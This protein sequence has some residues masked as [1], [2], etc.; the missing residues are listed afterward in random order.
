MAGRDMADPRSMKSAIYAA[1]DIY[2][3]RT[4]YDELVAGRMT[5]Q[6]PDTE[7]RPKG[8]RIIE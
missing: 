8:G 3:K 4:D 1:I 2:N 7:I 6:L 5:I